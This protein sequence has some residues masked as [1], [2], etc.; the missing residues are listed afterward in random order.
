MKHRFANGGSQSYV[1]G[2]PITSNLKVSGSYRPNM[3]GDNGLNVLFYMYGK[4]SMQLVNGDASFLERDNVG[5]SSK[6]NYLKSPQLIDPYVLNG[7]NLRELKDVPLNLLQYLTD[8]VKDLSLPTKENAYLRGQ[9]PD[10]DAVINDIVQNGNGSKYYNIVNDNYHDLQLIYTNADLASKFTL[11]RYVRKGWYISD[12]KAKRTSI[13][14]PKQLE[15]LKAMMKGLKL[16]QQNFPSSMS[17]LIEE[18]SVPLGTNAGYPIF[19]AQMKDGIDEAKLEVAVQLKG[20]YPNVNFSKLSV[21]DV[22]KAEQFMKDKFSRYPFGK[23][24]HATAINRRMK[25][26]GK[27]IPHFD[28][29][30]GLNFRGM[31]Y[32][33]PDQ[34]KVWMNSYPANLEISTFIH[35]IKG[36]R[37]NVEGMYHDSKSRKKYYGRLKN[38]NFP[39]IFENDAVGFDI[40]MS[41]QHYDTLCDH[42]AELTS[43]PAVASYILK[44]IRRYPIIIPDPNNVGTD[45]SAIVLRTETSLPSGTLATGEIGSF[46]T[47]WMVS[48]GYVLSGHWTLNDVIDYFSGKTLSTSKPIP[49]ISGDDNTHMAKD[50]PDMIK[51]YRGIKQSYEE[52]GMGSEIVIGDRFLM[53]HIQKG[54]DEP[55][56]ARAIQQRL[57]NEHIPDSWQKY[58]LGF[59]TA[60]NGMNGITYDNSVK[61]QIGSVTRSRSEMYDE[62]CS[63]TYKGIHDLVSTARVKIPTVIDFTKAIADKNFKLA[64]DEGRKG[65]KQSQSAMER[66][67]RLAMKSDKATV[68]RYISS[69]LRDNY[70]INSQ[71]MLDTVED[72][73]N[74]AK[75]MIANLTGKAKS[76]YKYAIDKLG[77]IP[78]N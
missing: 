50:L 65:M 2:P 57:N 45:K 27:A 68:E 11:Q 52:F 13:A 19:K 40:N 60:T 75:D 28:P 29:T 23:E 46:F 18:M 32:M 6:V 37:K 16:N 31:T 67:V 39:F 24:L 38:G 14:N 73:S 53:R 9:V 74:I 78:D 20:A 17:E 77:I 26:T 55:V 44:R 76:M 59:M 34:R 33:Y 25:P 61:D 7:N 35:Q 58:F 4:N 47:G 56:L 8:Y 64:T 22:K 48:Y 41:I 10:M 42:L 54:I 3:I 12:M 43:N 62:A 15:V 51:M 63:I 36:P 70:T 30:A 66:M 1:L 21:N 5:R 71:I 72:T 49:L 69:L